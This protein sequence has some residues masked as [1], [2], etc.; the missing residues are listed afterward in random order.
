M[1]ISSADEYS[2]DAQQLSAAGIPV[3]DRLGRV[4][5]D[6][7]PPADGLRLVIVAA[8]ERCAVLVA[9]ALALGRVV[10][11]MEH[12]AVRADPAARDALDDHVV[13]QVHED[14]GG[15][16]AP[17]CAE[18]LV[19]R[20][21]LGD[22]AGESVEQ[23]SRVG[24][25]GQR[26]GDHGDDERVRHQPSGEHVLGRGQTELGAAAAMTP[27]HVA[28]GDVGEVELVAQAGRLGALARSRRTQ[29]RH[30][31]GRRRGG[32][33]RRMRCGWAGEAADGSAP[34]WCVGARTV[35]VDTPTP[36]GC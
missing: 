30:G 20:F 25:V 33:K 21:R 6:R 1:R 22:G 23:E 18:Q 24:V 34:D 36:A 26:F 4:V 35:A 9:D 12:V 13:R 16:P 19:E 29:E 2:V 14:R 3:D 15:E 31:E 27:Q 28:G 8:D 7:E 5:V 17:A 11:V 32:E 10:R